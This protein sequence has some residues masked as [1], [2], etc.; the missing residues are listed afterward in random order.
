M[1]NK[2]TADLVFARKDCH[3]QGVQR[4][5]GAQV[6]SDLPAND[7]A[8]KQIGDERRIGKAAGGVHVRDVSDP[9][10][11]RRGRGKVPPQQVSGPL[12]AASGTVVRGF[13]RLAAA[14]AMPS[15]P[16]SRSTVHRAASMPS[17]RSCSHTFRAPYTRRPFFRSS[18]TRMISFLS[19][20]SRCSRRDGW[21]SRFFAA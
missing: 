19:H 7:L 17:R 4:E 10:A 12:L 8:G 11:V 9:A 21:R 13:F 16:I 3:L 1:M 14:P 2:L 15:S 6:L 20:S 5:L 18:Q